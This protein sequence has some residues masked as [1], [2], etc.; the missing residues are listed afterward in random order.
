MTFEYIKHIIGYKL[1]AGKNALGLITLMPTYAGM[2]KM[3]TKFKIMY[4]KSHHDPEKAGQ[5]YKPTEGKM[6]VMNNAGVFFLFDGSDFY[7]SI[8][9]LSTSLPSYDVIWS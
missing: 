6:V 4:P 2:K 9:K 1:R 5:P 3:R 7:P 8:Q